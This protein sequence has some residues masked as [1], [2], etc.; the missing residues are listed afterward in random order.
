MVEIPDESLVSQHDEDNVI[1]FMGKMDTEPNVIAVNYFAHQIFPKLKE[2]FPNLKF[3]IVGSHPER[4][5]FLSEIHDIKVTGFV[6]SLEPYYQSSTIVVAPMLTGAGIQNK[7]IQ[8]M[9]YGC[10]VAT[11][12]IGAE[13]LT[14]NNNEIA[15]IDGTD[16]W[17]ETIS[18]LLQ[19]RQSRIDM[20]IKAREYVRNNLSPEIISRQFWDFIRSGGIEI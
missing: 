5:Q 9:S 2:K 7:I 10:C 20:G 3:K 4:I 14:I 13:G 18:Y 16:K 8:G 11:T 17:I 1:S 6:D 12:T 15:I 19:N